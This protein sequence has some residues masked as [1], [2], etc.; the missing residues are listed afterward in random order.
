[1]MPFP[2]I[3]STPSTESII[4]SLSCLLYL[5]TSRY[6]ISVFYGDDRIAEL[7]DWPLQLPLLTLEPRAVW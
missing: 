2:R 4:R 7:D 3:P 6:L 5:S 1:M